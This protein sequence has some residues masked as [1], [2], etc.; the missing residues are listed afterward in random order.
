LTT[1]FG[2]RGRARS[3]APVP[4][5]PLSRAASW[6]LVIVCLHWVPFTGTPVPMSKNVPRPPCG[7]ATST[8]RARVD[9]DSRPRP[10]AG[11]PSACAGEKEDGPGQ[12]GSRPY[13][14]PGFPGPKSSRP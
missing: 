5:S 9:T 14:G 2:L 6:A 12:S 3:R 13:D 10:R 4:S 11:T 7:R 8:A 1:E